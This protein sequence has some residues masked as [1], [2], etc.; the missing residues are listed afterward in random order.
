LRV[1]D[2]LV[3]A[4][5]ALVTAT[6]V[7]ALFAGLQAWVARGATNQAKRQADLLAGSLDV[8][9]RLLEAT[10]RERAEAAPL[11]IRVN[12]EDS[13]AGRATPDFQND[14]QT[15]AMRL[16]SVKV[17]E[18]PSGRDLVGN[19]PADGTIGL[20]EGWRVPVTW[21]AARVGVTIIASVWG[22]RMG[23]PEM[24]REFAFRIDDDGRLIDLA[25]T[26]PRIS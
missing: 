19:T 25:D 3:L 26:S 7:L 8:S 6:V 16:T 18:L 14:S 15:A 5:W 1:D 17:A 12:A 23:G 4:T 24:S 13:F 9:R 11:Q 10:E 22:R 21:D 2:P 20:G